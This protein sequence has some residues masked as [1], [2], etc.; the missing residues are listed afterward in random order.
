[1]LDDDRDGNVM[2][3]LFFIVLIES[4]FPFVFLSAGK[5]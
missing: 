4:F 3:N 1:V 5:F 2:V